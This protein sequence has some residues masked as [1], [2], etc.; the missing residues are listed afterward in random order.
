MF[1]KVRNLLHIKGKLKMKEMD[2]NNTTE[3]SVMCNRLTLTMYDGKNLSW[4]NSNWKG[5][6]Y[7]KL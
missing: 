3:Q 5:R 1:G 2:I 4:T 6:G 7:I